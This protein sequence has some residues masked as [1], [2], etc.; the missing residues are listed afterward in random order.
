M[1]SRT[2]TF[3]PVSD[4]GG[5]EW[6]G[7]SRYNTADL[8]PYPQGPPNNRGN[9][10]TSPISGSSNGAPPPSNMDRKP[11]GNPSPPNSVG[12]SSY[13]TNASGRR[14]MVMEE[15]LA[16]HYNILRR[17][18]AQS[19]HDEKG[20]AKPNRAR[21]KLL[22]LSAVQFQELSTDVFDELQRRQA[23]EN[24]RQPADSIPTS[25][26]RFPRNGLGAS[27]NRLCHIDQ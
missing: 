13:G 6:S 26:L 25:G 12:R 11:G 18:L 5:S 19:S 20:D 3:S 9:L 14:T 24:P 16:H 27:I 2:G 8:P 21:D 15:N 22:R 7:I 17:Y 23:A 4:G 10:A 1:N